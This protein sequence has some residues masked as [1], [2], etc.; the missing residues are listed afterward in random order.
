MSMDENPATVGRESPS[1]SP[2]LF[3]SDPHDECTD[4]GVFS[5]M[6]GDHVG[7]EEDSVHKNGNG[8]YM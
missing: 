5:L 3:D 7:V 1:S 8:Y 4:D 6:G 2:V